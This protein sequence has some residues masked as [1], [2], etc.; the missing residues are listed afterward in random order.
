MSVECPVTRFRDLV[1]TDIPWDIATNFWV[2]LLSSATRLPSKRFLLC[3]LWAG[4]VNSYMNL[5]ALASS[6]SGSLDLEEDLISSV[7][8]LD[9][10][11][12][13]AKVLSSYELMIFFPLFL[14]LAEL[15]CFCAW[16]LLT[17]SN[18]LSRFSRTGRRPDLTV[19][20]SS[21]LYSRLRK[22]ILIY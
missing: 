10:F 11:D 21:T 5:V 13:L 18:T 4:G 7:L 8:S 19:A 15:F 2:S 14:M 12:Y 3:S 1:L 17:N 16:I 20:G 22:S 6:L 9:S